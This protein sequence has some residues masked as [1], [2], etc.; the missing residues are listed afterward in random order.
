VVVVAVVAGHF[1][2]A[3]G[4]PLL[5]L[6]GGGDGDFV[7]INYIS[8]TLHIVLCHIPKL[9]VGVGRRHTRFARA[10]VFARGF[11]IVVRRSRVARWPC[12]EGSLAPRRHLCAL[13]RWMSGRI[14]RG[15]WL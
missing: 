2:E 7:A 15:A 1:F 11:Q 9:D 4:L 12:T 10:A 5:N 14:S 8:P 3:E 6:G 13:S